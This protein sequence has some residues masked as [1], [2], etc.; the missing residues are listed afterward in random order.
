MSDLV[1]VWDQK[2]VK[3]RNEININGLTKAIS[4]KAESFE[5]KEEF[6]SHMQRICSVEE[7][8]LQIIHEID[9]I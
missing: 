8:L 5:M 9:S 1:R 3:V 4:T 6:G 7:S 2:I